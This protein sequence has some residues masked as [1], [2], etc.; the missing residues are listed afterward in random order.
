MNKNDSK[1]Y[2]FHPKINPVMLIPGI[3]YFI[4]VVKAHIDNA[5]IFVKTCNLSKL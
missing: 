1:D 3:H 4:V 2:D 5:K